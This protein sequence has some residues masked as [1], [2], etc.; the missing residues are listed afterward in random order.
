MFLKSIPRPGLPG[1]AL[2]TQWSLRLMTLG[3]LVIFLCTLYPFHFEL[4]VSGGLRQ[5]FS[6]FSTQASRADFVAN[7][8][9]FIPF[10]LGLTGCL[11]LR[12]VHPLVQFG[13]V[14]MASVALS[15]AVE[16]AQV[17]IPSR[18]SSYVDV[19]TNAVGG[20]CGYFCF[21]GV[22]NWIL[23]AIAAF[24]AG[25]QGWIGQWRTRYL[26]MGF[27]GYLS[28]TLAL[29]VGIC[30]TSLANWDVSLPLRL[31]G[32]NPE[33]ALWMGTV[34]HVQWRDRALSEADVS[35]WFRDP[36]WQSETLIA[37]YELRNTQDL[38]DRTGQSPSLIWSTPPPA[39]A[40]R[41]PVVAGVPISPNHWLQT[42]TGLSELSQRIQRSAQFSFAATITSSQAVQNTWW[43]H[44]ILTLGNTHYRE[45]FVIGQLG[46]NLVIWVQT[47]AN[48]VNQGGYQ[49][50]IANA[51]ND[52]QPHRLIL[53]YNGFTVSVNLDGA[54]IRK[55][56]LVKEVY[57]IL[58]GLLVFTPLSFILSLIANSRPLTAR[59]WLGLGIGMVMPPI[60]LEGWFVY[61][62]DN[63]HSTLFLT[64]SIMI[65]TF[66]IFRDRVP[67]T[68]PQAQP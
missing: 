62:G 53:T 14:A 7:I 4:T 20:I 63:S 24:V 36:R 51:L 26:W 58:G 25:L 33:Q 44:Q 6:H 8:V 55:S 32:K 64:M 12:Q 31:G 54:L 28:L 1:V 66:F 10:G 11:W 5:I 35:Q 27:L 65:G 43:Y 34:A 37:D 16:L 49:I 56:S 30:S 59:H 17:F 23:G 15:G 21:Y 29:L 50:F 60:V 47:A 40:S 67:A 57:T 45:N 61:L 52:T 42:P 48:Q 46:P 68:R 19:Y 3:S 39:A 2:A 13:I 41:S 9:L 38:S 22:G 18:F